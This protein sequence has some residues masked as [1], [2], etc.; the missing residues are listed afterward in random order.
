MTIRYSTVALL[1][2]VLLFSAACERQVPLVTTIKDVT[3]APKGFPEIPFPEE[4]PYSKAKW[5]LGKKL[6]YDKALSVDHSIS[7]A[8]CHKVANAFS[9]NIAKS[10]GAGNAA[11]TR[12]APTLANVA[13]HPYY[14]REG[15]LPTLEMQ[16]LVPI[17]EHNEFNYNIIDIAE[18]LN[19]IPEYVAESKAVFN[20]VPD[21]YVITRALATFE[22]TIVS[23]N[24][25]YDRY[26]N[27]NDRAI[28]AA[29]KR[30][31]TLFF[32][33]K[34]N[35]SS[36][37]SG[38]NFTSY[39]FENNGLYKDYPD[40]GRERL[41]GKVEDRARFKVPTLRNIAVT[42]PYMHDGSIATLEAVVQH[43][44]SGGVVHPNKNTIIRPLGLTK[45]EQADLVAFL[46]SLTDDEFITNQSFQE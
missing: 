44:N 22:R 8:S 16:I 41:T 33:D 31:M 13:Y 4:N 36:C 32:S 1:L 19:Q 28:T 20:R 34:T 18:R 39:G 9:D 29:A 37:H 27:G 14:T 40:N 23:G 11:G 45:E 12:N 24:S 15:G 42:A 17:Q 2:L 35:C 25:Q 38:F 10:F 30:G 46:R 7:C 26:T 43:Y 21:A 6:F 3:I 5:E